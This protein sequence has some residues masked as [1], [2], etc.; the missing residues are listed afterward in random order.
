MS[1]AVKLAAV[2]AGAVAVFATAFGVGALAGPLDDEPAASESAHGHDAG[3]D[4]DAGESPDGHGAHAAATAAGL[5]T[6][7]AGHTLTLQSPR[8]GA[9]RQPLRFTVAGPDGAPVQDYDVQH[10]KELHLI[11]VRRDLTGFQHLHPVRDAAGTW[12]VPVR[13][14]P[15]AWR[16]FADVK[17]RGAEAMVLGTDLLVAGDTDPAPL[18]EDA[19]GDVVDGYAVNLGA[20]LVA[21][22]ESTLTLT[23]SR[24]GE[25]VTDLEPY[26]GAHGHLVVLRDGDLAYL[27]AHPADD[28]AGPALRF[29]ATFPGPGR[30]RMFLDFQHRGK[31]RTAELTVTVGNQSAAGSQHGGQHGGQHGEEGGGHGH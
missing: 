13:L 28:G 17:P 15:G 21:G 27:H 3:G 4:G 5:A 19:V 22:R 11:V 26:L 25:P 30:Y 9:G 6:S 24:D 8:L 12:S 16:V 1:T 7:Q 29:H 23:V 10:E 18:G 31:V 14:T 20:S 2:L